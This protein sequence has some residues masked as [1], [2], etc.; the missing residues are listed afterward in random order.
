MLR[1]FG[2]GP[3]FSVISNPQKAGNSL[4]TYSSLLD[5]RRVMDDGVHVSPGI[6]K[7]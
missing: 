4:V 1:F 7:R 5:S 3:I 2:E 6:K